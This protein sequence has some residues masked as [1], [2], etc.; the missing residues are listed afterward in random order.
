MQNLVVTDAGDGIFHVIAGGRRLEAIRSLIEE[1]RLPSD[2]AV[3][4]QIVG[5][6]NALE[7]SLAENTVRLAM[8]PADQFEAFAALIDQGM[9]A[10]EVASRFGVEE[11][12]VMKRMKLARVAPPLLAEYRDGGLTLECLMA[13]TI[14]D[15]HA[16]AQGVQVAPGLAER[17]PV[18]HPRRADREDGRGE[19]Q[20]GPLRRAGRLCRRRRRP[21]RSVRRRSVS[22]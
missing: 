10:A 19:Q 21:R 17:R 7:L 14:T 16:P 3:P 11:S 8:H 18:H 13:F 15:D 9:T 12:L 2:Y 20:A 4:C 6:C 5:D 1:G 22:D